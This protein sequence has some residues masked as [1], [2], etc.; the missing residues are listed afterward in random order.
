MEQTEKNKEKNELK[1][2]RETRYFT[3]VQ[4]PTEMTI[5]VLGLILYQ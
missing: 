1:I 2:D 5:T 3:A 4:K